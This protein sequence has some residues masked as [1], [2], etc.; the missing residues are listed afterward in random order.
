MSRC[1]CDY[2]HMGPPCAHCRH[3]FYGDPPAPE[4]PPIRIFK[5]GKPI[6]T[7]KGFTTHYVPDY[8]N[9]LPVK[10]LPAPKGPLVCEGPLD[11]IR[12]TMTGEWRVK[13]PAKDPCPRHYTGDTELPCRCQPPPCGGCGGVDGHHIGCPVEIAERQSDVDG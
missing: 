7:F 13:T 11:Y 3:I 6:G 12:F 1:T 5:D 8:G 9:P 2:W 4:P 10:T